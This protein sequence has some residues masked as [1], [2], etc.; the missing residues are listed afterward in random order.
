MML[1]M[2]E[3]RTL[4]FGEKENMNN[5]EERSNN[6]SEESGTINKVMTI[7]NIMSMCRIVLIVP[8]IICF[9]NE[10]YIE[11]AVLIITSGL[12]DCFDGLIARKL[13]QVTAL[14]KIL[15]PIADKLTLISVG[16]CLCIYMPI[17][18]PVMVI[19][20]AKDFL[21][22]LGGM[23]LIKCNVT[24]SPA[25]WYGKV[26]TIMFYFSVCL[27]VFL[28][29]F[30]QYE[31]DVLSFVLLSITAALMIFALVMYYHIYSQQMKQVKDQVKGVKDKIKNKIK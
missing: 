30:F 24:P 28:K 11:A 4:E 31:N 19:L 25:K 14:G 3:N 17:V 12:T 29:A 13:N 15:D 8:F 23:A 2:G 1:D 7:P 27:I 10:K 16:I 26:G 5:M 18:T 21:M 20:M 22:L 6:S 9:L